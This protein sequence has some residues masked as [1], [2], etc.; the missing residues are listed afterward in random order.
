[1]SAF[2]LPKDVHLE[3]KGIESAF[4][5]K[6]RVD[7]VA[8]T[9]RCLKLLLENGG[10]EA[11][12][13]IPSRKVFA[14]A[15]NRDTEVLNCDRAHSRI[16]A[17]SDAGF[18][19]PVALKDAVCFE[20]HPIRKTI[21]KCAERITSK[22][23]KFAQYSA[24]EVTSGSVGSSHFNHA[25]ECA[26]QGVECAY[27]S[28]SDDKG[29]MSRAKIEMMQPGFK[30]VFDKGLKWR[31]VRWEVEEQYPALP[32]LFQAGLTAGGQVQVG[33]RRTETYTP[34]SVAHNRTYKCETSKTNL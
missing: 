9:E 4:V 25:L 30:T 10:A 23:P 5:E 17:V 21:G 18:S 34:N 32:L 14:H 27:P 7:V 29:R 28:I 12:V 19:L 20:D 16:H 6:R 15:Q 26:I 24:K 13:W 11:D 8:M 3:V 22:S 1:M 31:R 33:D 2:Q